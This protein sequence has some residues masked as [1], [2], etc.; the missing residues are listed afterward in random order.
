MAAGATFAPG[1]GSEVFSGGNIPQD[2]FEGS[3]V[4]HITGAGA[5][6]HQVDHCCGGVH[7]GYFVQDGG[8]NPQTL[9]QAT[10]FGWNGQA[11][12]PPLCQGFDRFGGE[13][14][15]RVH[16]VSI[17]GD[18]ISRDLP[19]FLDQGGLFFV[20]P[21]HKLCLPPSFTGEF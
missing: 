14:A 9:T 2:F 6:M 15:F 8:G 12:K 18:R 20:Q 11:E 7:L 16:G 19:G 10:I 17:G 3:R 21:V 5:D 4:G 13:T 1:Q